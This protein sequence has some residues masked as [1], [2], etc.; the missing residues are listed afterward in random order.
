[1][2]TAFRL[3]FGHNFVGSISPKTQAAFV[4]AKANFTCSSMT[5]PT[6]LKNERELIDGIFTNDG[7]HHTLTLTNVTLQD[8]GE[9]E[10]HG[11]IAMRREFSDFAKLTVGG[12][13]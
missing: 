4:G 12:K 3:D 8:T 7:H 2:F 6:W 9:F 1:M 13:G 11:T 5:E 10:C